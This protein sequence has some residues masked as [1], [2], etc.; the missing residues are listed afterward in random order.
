MRCGED[1][2]YLKF[3]KLTNQFL[4]KMVIDYLKENKYFRYDVLK[5]I[6][7]I[8]PYELNT[9]LTALGWEQSEFDVNGWQQDTWYTYLHKNYYFKLIMFYSG[10]YR[11]IE[12]YRSDIN[13]K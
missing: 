7:N 13:D 10:Y 11:K 1:S 6:P 8:S 5:N 2:I 3:T 9:I 12:L 4:I